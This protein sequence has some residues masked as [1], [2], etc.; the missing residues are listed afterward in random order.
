MARE[1]VLYVAQVGLH[2]FGKVF[3]WE[4]AYLFIPYVKPIL[5][6]IEPDIWGYVMAYI[7]G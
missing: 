3:E 2:Y 6:P 4:S 1:I 5:S 7:I